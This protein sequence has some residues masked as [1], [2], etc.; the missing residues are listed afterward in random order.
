MPVVKQVR[1]ISHCSEGE[2]TPWG[3]MGHL[4]KSVLEMLQKVLAAVRGFQGGFRKQAWMQSGSRANSIIVYLN[5]SYLG[6]GK[7]RKI[8]QL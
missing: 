1:F 6:K 4:S 8:L 3:T 2:H 7:T 5:K